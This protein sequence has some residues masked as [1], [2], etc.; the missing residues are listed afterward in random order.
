MKK[1]L[2]TVLLISAMALAG[3]TACSADPGDLTDGNGSTASENSGG[4]S[5]SESIDGETA[6][7]NAK[8]AALADAGLTEDQTI[9][10]GVSQDFDDG[11]SLIEVDIYTTDMDYSYS[12]K[13]DDGTIV[14]RESSVPPKMESITA[15]AAVTPAQ[16]AETALA[17]VNGATN[18]NLRMEYDFDDG[19]SLYEVEIIYNGVDYSMEINAD[20]GDIV[21]S[22]QEPLSMD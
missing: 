19:I 8:S 12:I 1:K 3:L 22:S 17:Q 20:T 21:Q 4:S 15:N 9:G 14:E 13:A 6:M 2:L 5:G 10:I 11:I 16:A 7:E 18:D